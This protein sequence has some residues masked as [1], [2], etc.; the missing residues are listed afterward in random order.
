MAGVFGMGRIAKSFVRKIRPFGNKVIY[1]VRN[2]L[3]EATERELGITFVT[4]DELCRSADVIVTLCPGTPETYH[5]LDDAQFG[6]M[7]E[8]VYIINTSRGSVISNDALVSALKTGKVQRAGLDV[9]DGEPEV[10]EYL[11]N[12]PRVT[13]TPRK[14]DKA[15][16]TVDVAA[17]SKGTIYA[18]ERDAFDNVRAFLETG[19][20]VSPVNGPF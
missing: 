17:Y 19:K 18:G 1:N 15:P 4:K 2:Q 12:N 16:L 10:P 13:I 8:G 6:M 14:S 9:V 5:L 7:R 3:D 20:P 11:C